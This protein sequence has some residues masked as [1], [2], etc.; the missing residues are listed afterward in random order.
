MTSNSGVPGSWTSL[1]HSSGASQDH[2]DGVWQV[3]THMK[4][5]MVIIVRCMSH[6][7]HIKVTRPCADVSSGTCM[8][9][10]PVSSTFHTGLE[11][12]GGE[13]EG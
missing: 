10:G 6:R 5:G 4:T 1:W 2:G 8:A 9:S 11:H 7:I 12:W 13:G 3:L